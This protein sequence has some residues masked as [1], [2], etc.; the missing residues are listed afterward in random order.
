MSGLNKVWR[1]YFEQNEGDLPGWRCK[2][3]G[4]LLQNDEGDMGLCPSCARY[5]FL[6]ALNEGVEGIG[7]RWTEGTPH[8][9][10][11]IKLMAEMQAVD[12]ANG[13]V[14]DLRTGGDGDNGETLMYLMDVV[15]EKRD[16]A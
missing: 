11:S 2:K 4:Y 13:L 10:E 14:V 16:S 5:A 1:R 7:V 15:F 12:S 6:G 8:H 9:P 3:H